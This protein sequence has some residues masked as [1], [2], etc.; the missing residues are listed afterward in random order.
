MKLST[1]DTITKSLFAMIVL[2]LFY[3]V[4]AMA[5]GPR[6]TTALFS[7]HENEIHSVNLPPFISSEVI[8]G[9]VVSEIVRAVLKE[10]KV[11]AVI[12]SHPVKRMLMYYLLQ[13][14]ALAVLGQHMHFSE[15]QK[16]H[17]I[18]IP[19]TITQQKYYYY[20]PAHPQGLVIPVEGSNLKDITYGAHRGE[21]IG[22]Y[23]KA[24][25]AIKYGR[26]TA[27][28]KKL[29]STEVDFISMS[30]LTVEWLLERYL[31]AEKENY[32]SMDEDAGTETLYIIFNRKHAEGEAAA[33]AF[34]KALSKMV[35]DG[36]LKRIVEKHL[37]KGEK[38]KL[39]LRR[40]E[41]FQ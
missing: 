2:L 6:V 17:L 13:E 23:E 11:D 14:N 34:R 35:R 12:T 28:L 4:S 15:E 19:L 27:L 21:D 20:K 8:D 39:Y 36:D 38:G 29:K 10:A 33:L 18:F 5:T 25:I 7:P 26:T 40:L 16:Q 9:G 1:S 32:V 31:K 41:T 22:A 3:P 30:P 37:G 24:G